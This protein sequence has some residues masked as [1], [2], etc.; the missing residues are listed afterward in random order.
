M[1]EVG[2]T[3]EVK[4]QT[5]L[6]GDGVTL[7]WTPQRLMAPTTT[8]ACQIDAAL[9]STDRR[10]GDRAAGVRVPDRRAAPR[11]GAPGPG[12]LRPLSG[13]STWGGAPTPPRCSPR[14]WCWWPE[15]SGRDGGDRP[16]ELYLGE[17]FT[18]LAA[19]MVEGR[20]ESHCDAPRG[21]RV[22]LA[23]GWVEVA[24]GEIDRHRLRGGLRPELGTFTEVGPLTTPRVDHR[25]VRLP[26]G[27]VLLTGGSQLE[28][29]LPAGP[30]LRGDLRSGAD[31]FSPLAATMVH[32]RSTHAM[33]DLGGGKVLLVGGA[34]RTSAPSG[35]T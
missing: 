33:V 7:R 6:D 18:L 3:G 8:H 15:G 4:G 31:T 27:R 26:D 34:T 22:L 23:G 30:R 10:A 21:G 24:P 28:G 17:V 2:G 11:A 25:A 5:V 16:G 35:S 32:T 13:R 19:R 12:H 9:R 14:T 1:G 29:R 20:A